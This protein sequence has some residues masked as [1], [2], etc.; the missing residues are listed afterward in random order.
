MGKKLLIDLDRIRDSSP[1]QSSDHKRPEGIM[2]EYPNKNGR[3]T[4]REIA[5]FRYTCRRCEDAPC[6][7]A[8]PADAL[9][10]G[11]EGI[12]RRSTNLCISCKSCVV[13]C[14]FGTMMN[15]FFEHHRTL[16]NYFDLNE[17]EEIQKFIDNNPPGAV[18]WVESEEDHTKDIYKLNDMVMIREKDWQGITGKRK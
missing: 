1:G 14:P 6:I 2:S 8:C 5:V 15:D 12:V 18:T 11:D 10:K 7:G 16:V 13:I 17:P 3:K 9:D 4:L